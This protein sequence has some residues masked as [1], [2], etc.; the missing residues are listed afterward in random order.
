MSVFGFSTIMCGL[1]SN[2]LLGVI[3]Y[4][5]WK[6]LLEKAGIKLLQ[7]KKIHRVGSLIVYVCFLSYNFT[8]TH[9]ANLASRNPHFVGVA[10]IPIVH[11]QSML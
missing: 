6:D 3:L 1:F 5:E 2:L 4:F 7:L 10:F 8:Y 9:F 11:R